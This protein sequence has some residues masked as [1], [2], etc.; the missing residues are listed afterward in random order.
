MKNIDYHFFL[1][2]RQTHGLTDGRANECTYQRMNKLSIEIR[3]GPQ[4]EL[5]GTLMPTQPLLDLSEVI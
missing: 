5:K 2:K 1:Q 3:G 4:G